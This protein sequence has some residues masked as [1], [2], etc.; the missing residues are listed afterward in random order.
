MVL[1]ANKYNMSVVERNYYDFEIKKH[2]NRGKFYAFDKDIRDCISISKNIIFA[3]HSSD[4][5]VIENST[6]VT[7]S[8]RKKKS[9]I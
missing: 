5:Y 9:I 8:L 3:Q 1:L 2:V 7:A 4:K 6:E